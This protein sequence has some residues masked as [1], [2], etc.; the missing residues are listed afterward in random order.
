MKRERPLA[1]I[2]RPAAGVNVAKARGARRRGRSRGARFYGPIGAYGDPGVGTDVEARAL[3]DESTNDRTI[4]TTTTSI[5]IATGPLE[6]S[7]GLRSGG[8]NRH[9]RLELR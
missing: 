1:V 5:L 7:A 8:W 3:A 6:M 2:T 4:A 9:R